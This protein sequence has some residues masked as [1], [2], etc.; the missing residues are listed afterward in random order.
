ME[1]AQYQTDERSLGKVIVSKTLVPFYGVILIA[2][3]VVALLTG[4]N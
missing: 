2:V 1:T 3:I 4:L